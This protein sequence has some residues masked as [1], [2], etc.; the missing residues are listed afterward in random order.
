MHLRS[1][2]LIVF[3]FA[4]SAAL[5]GYVGI[6]Y[7]QHALQSAVQSPAPVKSESCWII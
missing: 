6:M 3:I 1:L 2:T 7:D 5:A 4:A